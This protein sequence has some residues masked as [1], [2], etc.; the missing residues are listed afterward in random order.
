VRGVGPVP[1]DPADAVGALR[2]VEAAQRSAA[3]GAPV[4]L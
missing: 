3:T 1:V 4:A 2:V